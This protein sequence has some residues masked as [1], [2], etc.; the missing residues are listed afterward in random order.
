MH[1][2]KSEQLNLSSLSFQGAFSSTSLA[3]PISNVANLY[4]ALLKADVVSATGTPTGAGET[5]SP[6]FHQLMQRRWQQKSTT[7]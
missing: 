6:N 2:P 3:V 7:R 5:A 1:L 4:N